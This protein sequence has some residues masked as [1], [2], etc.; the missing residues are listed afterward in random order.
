LTAIG[1]TIAPRNGIDT[2]LDLSDEAQVESLAIVEHDRWMAERT[3]HGWTFG[4][5]RDEQARKHP[6]I[7]PWNELTEVDR[8]KDRDAV[9]DIPLVLADFGLQ[10]VRLPQCTVTLGR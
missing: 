9:R 6:R 3:A 8:D 10:I 1:C 2:D 4:E 5:V 7:R